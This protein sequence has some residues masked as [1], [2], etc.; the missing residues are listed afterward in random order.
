MDVCLAQGFRTV[1]HREHLGYFDERSLFKKAAVAATERKLAEHPE[2]RN[3]GGDG[4][5]DYYDE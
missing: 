2:L 1:D 3:M 5:D 4:E